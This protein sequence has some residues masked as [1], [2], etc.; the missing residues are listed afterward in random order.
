MQ[1]YFITDTIEVNGSYEM[2]VTHLH[3][4][5]NVMR[6][7]VEDQ[8]TVVDKTSTA[9]LVELTELEPMTFKVIERLDYDVE[10]PVDISLFSPLLK[11]D[12]M[13]LVIQKSTELGVHEFILYKAERSIVK[14]DA[15]KESARQ[16]RFE[17]IATEASEQSKRTKVPTVSFTEQ[18][19]TI[20]FN[21]FDLVLFAYENNNLTGQSI[22]DILLANDA[23]TIALVFGPEGGFTENEVELFKAHKNISLGHRILRAETA[24]LYGLS[25]IGSYYE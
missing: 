11:G 10:L 9:Y 8:F 5:K 13:D 22:K 17:K 21:R 14:L 25:V 12:K 19:K 23:Q 20:D 7:R 24:P 15:K 3:H 1:R 18:L 16:T 6:S 2:E 4:I